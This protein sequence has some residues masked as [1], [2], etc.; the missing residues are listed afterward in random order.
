M[1]SGR[2]TLIDTTSIL[3]NYLHQ[4]LSYDGSLSGRPGNWL[5]QKI[6]FTNLM[7]KYKEFTQTLSLK[8]L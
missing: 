7:R 4:D 5:V 6:F 2:E 8:T 3:N 1:A